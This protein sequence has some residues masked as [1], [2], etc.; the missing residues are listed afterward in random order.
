MGIEDMSQA[1]LRKAATKIVAA[2][3]AES[4][5]FDQEAENRIPRFR[6]S[7]KSTRIVKRSLHNTDTTDTNQCTLTSSST[8]S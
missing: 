6:A 3:T 2:K 8:C 1:D 7:G 4:T 5:L